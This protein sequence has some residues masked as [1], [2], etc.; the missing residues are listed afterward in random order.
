MRGILPARGNFPSQLPVLL[1]SSTLFREKEEPWF[2][3][4]INPVFVSL[5]L[6]GQAKCHPWEWFRT[7]DS[8]SRPYLSIKVDPFRLPKRRGGRR[9]DWRRLERLRFPPQAERDRFN[10]PFRMRWRGAKEAAVRERPRIPNSGKRFQ[11]KLPNLSRLLLRLRLIAGRRLPAWL[12]MKDVCDMFHTHAPG[13]VP[14]GKWPAGQKTTRKKSFHSFFFQMGGAC[15]VYTTTSL[16]VEFLSPLLLFFP[17]VP[18]WSGLLDA[19]SSSGLE[20]CS[21]LRLLLFAHLLE[22]IACCTSQHTNGCRSLVYLSI[23]YDDDELLITFSK[24]K[25]NF[26][27]TFFFVQT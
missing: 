26:P 18:S 3:I 6:S 22:G 13:A 10:R 11:R 9:C 7:S 4:G 17:V 19:S 14:Y 12:T 8:F 5:S 24:E 16:R 1:S 25:R 15:W 27:P 2:F 20:I 21:L 23:R